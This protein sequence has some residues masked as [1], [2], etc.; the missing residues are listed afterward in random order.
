[1][2]KI[3]LDQYFTSKETAEYC[4]NKAIEIIG[5]ENITE[6]IETSAGEGVFL[7]CIEKFTP[8]I[9]YQA[10]DID[11]KDERVVEQDYL[12]LDMEYIKGRCVIGNPPFGH[13]SK[14]IIKF[15]KKSIKL[16]EYI[17]FIMPISFMDNVKQIYEFD[18]VHSEDLGLR[19]YSDR[20]IHCCLNI[21][22]KNV[23]GEYNKNPI[24]K[25]KLKKDLK[26]IE[27]RRANK[28]CLD[29]DYGFCACGDL[30]KE[31]TFPNSDQ[32]YREFYVK[33]YNDSYKDEIVDILKNVKW[34]DIYPQSKM[35]NVTQT[36]VYK[37][38]KECIP[39]LE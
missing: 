32:F 10:Y 11:K 24:Q 27:I 26:I 9:P 13:M 6:F 8:E 18:L 4:F 15:Y 28:K 35:P 37:Y 14:L 1:M 7:D 30:G 33:I 20:K 19:E 17:S 34:L 22:K 25:F 38:L 21:Y 5:K 12:T 39:E 31:I 29:Y 36:Q 23:S 3:N 2:S 16:G